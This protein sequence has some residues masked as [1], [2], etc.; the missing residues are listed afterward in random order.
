[1][2]KVIEDI[3]CPGRKESS[4][5]N[6]D[7]GSDMVSGHLVGIAMD[8]YQCHLFSCIYKGGHCQ[9]EPNDRK[10]FGSDLNVSKYIPPFRSQVKEKI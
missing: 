9:S 2:E 10:E 8:I 1:M 5:P 7:H 6:D 3:S 4:P